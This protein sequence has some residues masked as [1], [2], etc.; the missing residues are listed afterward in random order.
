MRFR[1]LPNTLQELAEEKAYFDT[2]QAQ[3]VPLKL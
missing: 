2:Q 3:R 1:E